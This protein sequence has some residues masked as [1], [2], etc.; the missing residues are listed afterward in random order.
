MVEAPHGF[1]TLSFFAV[2]VFLSFATFA[3]SVFKGES[4][5]SRSVGPFTPAKELI[6]GRAAMV[7][8][9]AS[10]VR[11]GASSVHVVQQQCM[12]KACCNVCCSPATP[13]HLRAT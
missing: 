6:N 4:L 13:L 11:F 5:N 12:P 9:G 8:A 2:V 3:P 1:A 10:R 7:S